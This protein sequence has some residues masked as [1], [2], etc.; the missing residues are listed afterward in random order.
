MRPMEDQ[1]REFSVMKKLKHPNIVPLL[2]I[3][4]EVSIKVVVIKSARNSL[5]FH[6]GQHHETEGS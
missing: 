6:S 4:E 1:M 3:E 5:T 2:D